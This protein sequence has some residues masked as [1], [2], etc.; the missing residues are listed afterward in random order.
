RAQVELP[1]SS[2]LQATTAAEAA[3]ADYVVNAVG[4]KAKT[5]ADLFCGVGPFALRLAELR[6]IYAADSDKDAIKAL[7]K[8]WR[9]AKGVREV[10]AKARDLFRDPL[11][12][13]ELNFEAVVLDPP[14]AGAQAQIAELAKS[15]VKTVI[16]VACDPRSFARDAATLV[17]AGYKMSD[18]VAVDQF[19]QST[20]IEM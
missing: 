4:P 12:Q 5:V 20:H 16:M 6:P 11:T 17:Q 15:K 18:L 9:Y 14:R 13:F 8:G 1:I 19:T 2:F 3:L 10:T 7:D